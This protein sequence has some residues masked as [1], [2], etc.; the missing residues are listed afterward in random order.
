MD[1]SPLTE[2]S[3]A[4]ENATKDNLLDGSWERAHRSSQAAAIP[5]MLGVGAIYFNGQSVLISLGMLVSNVSGKLVN[6]PAGF[7]SCMFSLQ[8]CLSTAEGIKTSRS[9]S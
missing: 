4:E 1:S 7:F 3:G 6:P 8:E 5:A 2:R 9:S